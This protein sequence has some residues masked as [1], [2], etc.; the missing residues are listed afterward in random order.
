MLIN[1]GKGIELNV[2]TTRLG[3]PTDLP[4]VAAHTVMIGLRNQ[5]MDSH[6]G[7]TAKDNPTDYVEKS[8][9][10]AKKKLEAMYQ[11]E[12]RTVTTREGDPVKAEATRLAINAVKAA[13]RKANRKA[14]DKAIRAKA[15]EV[16]E[17][18]ME[19]AAKNVEAA[20]DIDIDI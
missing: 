15:I 6:A 9:A 5:L 14:D 17:R 1:I 10:I 18:F 11:G 13:L 19:Q 12:I 20:A 3:F 8:E 2:D 7:M 4:P 16:R